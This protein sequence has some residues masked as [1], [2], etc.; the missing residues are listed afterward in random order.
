MIPT[1]QLQ[2]DFRIQEVKACNIRRQNHLP[3]HDDAPR[4]AWHT[5]EGSYDLF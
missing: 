4:A 1:L 3:N 2:A 5:Y